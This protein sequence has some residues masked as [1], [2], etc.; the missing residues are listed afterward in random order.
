MKAAP[1]AMTTTDAWRPRWPAWTA[2]GRRLMRCASRGMSVRLSQGQADRH[3]H[4]GLGVGELVRIESQLLVQADELERVPALDGDA[5][6][7]RETVAEAAQ[8]RPASGEG[9]L[10]HPGRLQLGQVEVGRAPDP[11]DAAG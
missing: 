1:T 7:G 6:G 4:V 11:V 2:A 5:E 9:E 3:G 10:A 8:A